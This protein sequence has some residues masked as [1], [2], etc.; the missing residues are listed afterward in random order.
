MVQAGRVGGHLVSRLVAGWRWASV[1]VD[2][3]LG[4]LDS[5]YRQAIQVREA[6]GGSPGLKIY[7]EQ[8]LSGR[9]WRFFQRRARCIFWQ[10][11]GELVHTEENQ[12]GGWGRRGGREDWTGEGRAFWERGRG[13]RS[14]SIGE[15]P[16]QRW[17]RQRALVPWIQSTEHERGRKSSERGITFQDV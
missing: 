4:L 12:V 15:Q 5:W 1:K 7:R 10:S 11:G 16:R 3:S 17:G 13:R 14:L 8:R 9:Q 2:N 6:R